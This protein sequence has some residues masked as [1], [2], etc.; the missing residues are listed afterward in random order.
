MTQ[1]ISKYMKLSIIIPV[2]NVEET[3]QRCVDSVTEQKFTDYEVLLIDDGSTD[4]SGLL[5]DNIAQNDGR[6]SVFHKPNGGLSD[7]RN[8]G[9]DR[10]RGEYITFIDSDDEIAPATLGI[11]MDIAETHPE[12]DIIEYPVLERPGTPSQHF[13]NPG[14]GDYPDASVWLSRHGLEHCW[15]CNK[16]YRREMFSGVRFPVGKK[17]EDVLTLAQLL[18]KRPHIGTTDRGMYMYHWNSSGIVAKSGTN[19]TPLLEAQLNLVSTLGIDTRRRKWHRL[20]LNMLTNQMYAYAAT[21][22]IMLRRQ[23]IM[24]KR[25]GGGTADIM[26]AL[27]LDVLGMRL[28]CILFKLM[29]R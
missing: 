8:Y 5:A 14:T 26:K 1:N 18:K 21:G 2:Y 28:T 17:Y 19:L 9:I 7:A 12:F 3:L 29:K 24:P 6:I 27:M 15:T 23:F 20:Y 4:K 13:Y 22:R 11:V 10:C 16:I 25:Y